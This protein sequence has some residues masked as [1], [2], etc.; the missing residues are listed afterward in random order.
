[1]NALSALSAIPA[2]SLLVILAAWGYDLTKVFRERSAVRANF[3]R[4]VFRGV[5]PGA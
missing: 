1:M 4:V 5:T 2:A 3:N